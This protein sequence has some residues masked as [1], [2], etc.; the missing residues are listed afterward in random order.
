M[1]VSEM[2]AASA[3]AHMEYREHV[4]KPLLGTLRGAVAGARA[5]SALVRACSHLA[6]ANVADPKR[7]D[8]DWLPIHDDLLD[9]YVHELTK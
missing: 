7:E 9:F 6:D 2:L 1:T 5:Y 8:A 3:Q 4:S